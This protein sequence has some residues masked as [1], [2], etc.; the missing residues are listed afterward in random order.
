[1]KEDESLRLIPETE[2]FFSQLDELNLSQ[3]LEEINEKYVP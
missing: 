2:D 1:M 3:E